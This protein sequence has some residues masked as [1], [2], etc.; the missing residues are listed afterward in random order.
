MGE[1]LGPRVSGSAQGVWLEW[2]HRRGS[3]VHPQ[4]ANVW[5]EKSPG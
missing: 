5:L 1:G 4:S 2:D 3:C